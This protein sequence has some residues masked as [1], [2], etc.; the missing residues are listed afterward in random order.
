MVNW[1]QSKQSIRWPVSHDHI[2]DL[3]LKLNKVTYSLSEMLTEFWFSIVSQAQVRWSCCKQVRVVRK[4]VDPEAWDTVM[5]YVK[6]YRRHNLSQALTADLPTELSWV[7]LRRQVSGCRR[8]K[9]FMWTSPAE[10][11][12]CCVW[13]KP[14]GGP[15]NKYR[16]RYFDCICMQEISVTSWL[17][18]AGY[19]FSAS[20]SVIK[21]IHLQRKF[22]IP[23]EIFP[24]L[25]TKYDTGRDL[26]SLEALAAPSTFF[27][28]E[29]SPASNLSH[30]KWQEQAKTGIT[31]GRFDPYY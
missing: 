5:A 30:H 22:M 4:R 20:V 25:R 8:W 28:F 3:S 18:I 9:D 13:R 1:H 24:V 19:F 16:T 7:Q 21:L 26:F 12:G 23:E 27:E 15:K 31:V 11:C 2:A 29:S 10:I 14:L 6:I 17:G